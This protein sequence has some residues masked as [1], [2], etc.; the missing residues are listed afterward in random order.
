[1]SYPILSY[2]ME[3]TKNRPFEMKFELNMN[4]ESIKWGLEI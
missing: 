2:G 1:M 4:T 3:Q